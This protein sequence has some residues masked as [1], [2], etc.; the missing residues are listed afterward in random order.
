M[1]HFDVNFYFNVDLSSVYIVL[2]TLRCSYINDNTS[3]TI[4]IRCNVISINII[5]F[6][7]VKVAYFLMSF[8]NNLRSKV[9][10]TLKVTQREF[11]KFTYLRNASL[12]TCYSSESICLN[13]EKLLTSKRL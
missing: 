12:F 6:N 3:S 5:N 9:L 2:T 11:I 1:R 4:N 13:N 10:C 8:M 7:L